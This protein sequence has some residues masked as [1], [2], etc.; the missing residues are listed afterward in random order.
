MSNKIQ[1][2]LYEEKD[3]VLN[4]TQDFP[5]EKPMNASDNNDSDEK[6][7]IIEEFNFQEKRKKSSCCKSL[8]FCCFPCFHKVDTISK[9][10]VGFR[11]TSYNKTYWS[12]KEEN[13]KY[14]VLLFLP[15]VIYNQFKQF[16]NFFI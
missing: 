1:N 4:N 5:A 16:G 9:R 2:K 10:I 7:S 15:T 8:L 3:M 13:H 14:N 6:I 12:N 11:D